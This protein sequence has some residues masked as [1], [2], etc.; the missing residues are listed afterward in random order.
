M[1]LSIPVGQKFVPSMYP[2]DAIEQ[3][4]VIG[5]PSG[6]PKLPVSLADPKLTGSRVFIYSMCLFIQ[7]EI[8]SDCYNK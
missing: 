8:R 4:A 1:L 6:T 5:C 2:K 7:I 3:E